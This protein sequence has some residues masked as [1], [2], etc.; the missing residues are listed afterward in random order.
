MSMIKVRGEGRVGEAIAGLDLLVD[1]NKPYL[2]SDSE[3]KQLIVRLGIKPSDLIRRELSNADC[4][5][6]INLC[7]VIDKSKSMN[8]LV[9]NVGVVFTGEKELNEDGETCDTVEGGVSRF[10]VAID[11]AK[12]VIEML[13]PNDTVS[14][15]MYDDEQVV[16][17]EDCTSDDKVEMLSKLDDSFNLDGGN[18]T[19]ITSALQEARRILSKSDDLKPKKIIFLT[20]GEPNVDTKADGIEEGHLLVNHNISVNCL[21]VGDQVDLL[22]LQKIAAPSNGRTNIIN[23]EYEAEKLFTSMFA[24]SQEIIATNATLRLWFSNI[25][26]VTDHFRG[27]P[28]NVYLGKVKLNTDR[29]HVLTLGQIERNQLYNYYY[30]ITIPPQ[31][32]YEL[33]LR[34]ARA[35]LE[36]CIP[37]LSGLEVIKRT[38]NIAVRYGKDKQRA[39]MVNSEIEVELKLAEVK[40]LENEAEEAVKR[41]EFTLMTQCYEQ[42][43]KIYTELK[44]PTEARAYEQVIMEYQESGVVSKVTM[45]EATNTS[46]QAGNNG[47][48][49]EDLSAEEFELIANFHKSKPKG[50]HS[51]EVN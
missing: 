21:G 47:R 41:E 34:L 8:H 46:S 36:Y 30:K 48:L 29:E 43:V 3:E 20:D 12:K 16:I 28:E 37:K 51:R 13:R 5:E 1:F 22:Y 26:R 32:D 42:I 9:D 31:E 10:E 25:I 15:L 38:C 50:R 39:S 7:I 6:G 40:R 23:T 33:P 27:T 2:L 45:N 24:Q 4:N 11:A 44:K 35:E 14:C 19:D 49:N 17:F 18:Q